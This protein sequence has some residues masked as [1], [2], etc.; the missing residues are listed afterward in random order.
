MEFVED[1]LLISKGRLEGEDDVIEKGEIDDDSE[2][3]RY[4]A[5]ADQVGG[6]IVSVEAPPQRW[7]R[8]GGKSLVTRWVGRARMMMATM[9]ATRPMTSTDRLLVVDGMQR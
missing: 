4:I 7:M 5:R 1:E 2:Q 3:G 9:V 6:A 8:V